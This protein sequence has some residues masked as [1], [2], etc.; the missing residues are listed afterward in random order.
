M[1]TDGA[2]GLLFYADT[3][4]ELCKA[5]WAFSGIASPD[6]RRFKNQSQFSE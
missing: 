5:F 4:A 2:F 3:V 6:C 1:G